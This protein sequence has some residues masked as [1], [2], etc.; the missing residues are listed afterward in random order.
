M[1]ACTVV[2]HSMELD[3]LLFSSFFMDHGNNNELKN[4]ENIALTD[5]EKFLK[6]ISNVAD[7]YGT[8]IKI[9]D[10]NGNG[11]IIYSSNLASRDFYLRSVGLTKISTG[12]YIEFIAEDDKK[13]R[14][15]VDDI[16]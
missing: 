15:L 6:Q 13:Y 1:R 8:A 11:R 5:P 16:S 3:E 4:T 14:L 10:K 2:A 9:V 7:I 12:T